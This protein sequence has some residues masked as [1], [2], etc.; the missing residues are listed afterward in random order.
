MKYLINSLLFSC[1]FLIVFNVHAEKPLSKEL[2]EQYAAAS[3]QLD[4][5]LSS[6]SDMN[7]N[8][9]QV[10]N[11][12][13]MLAFIR[14]LD[15]YPEFKAGV[16]NKGFDDIEDYLNTGTRV[17][18]ATFSF[19]MRYSGSPSKMLETMKTQLAETKKQ[20]LQSPATIT[21][22][23]ASIEQMTQN[24]PLMEKMLA[25]TLAPDLEFVKEHNSWINKVMSAK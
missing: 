6:S 4:T 11:Q 14:T 24:L 18:N 8:T 2:I 13:E 23:E 20:G 3:K 15:I 22:M 7:E 10:N 19:N 21:Q 17:F 5:L 9:T 12:N 16:I 1:L 25:D